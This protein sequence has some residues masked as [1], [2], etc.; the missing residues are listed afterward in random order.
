MTYGRPI[1]ACW[2]ATSWKP[3]IQKAYFADLQSASGQRHALLGL[4]AGSVGEPARAPASSSRPRRRLA[5]A[6]AHTHPPRRG[7]PRRARGEFKSAASSDF[8]HEI[9]AS[10]EPGTGERGP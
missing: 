5:R 1:E 9:P 6:R 4:T 2:K 3:L 10:T 7:G 8:L